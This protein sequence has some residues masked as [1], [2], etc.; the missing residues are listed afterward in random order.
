MVENQNLGTD[1]RLEKSIPF[2]RC[3]IY[4]IYLLTKN[5]NKCGGK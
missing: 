4:F 3:N 1:K 5:E 2:A